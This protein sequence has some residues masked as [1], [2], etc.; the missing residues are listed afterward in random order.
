[1]KIMEHSI[2]AQT[3]QDAYMAGL[4]GMFAEI[5]LAEQLEL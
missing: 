2:P 3:V 5:K 1:L 4:N